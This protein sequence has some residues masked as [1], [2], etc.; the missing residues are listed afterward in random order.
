M[1]KLDLILGKLN[2][3]EE[4]TSK[5]D[6]IESDINALKA[7][8]KEIKQEVKVITEATNY[9]IFFP[10]TYIPVKRIKPGITDS[11]KSNTFNFI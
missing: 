7:D 5:L 8:S 4:K 1:D 6:K 10:F 3:L 9:G 2:K 11:A